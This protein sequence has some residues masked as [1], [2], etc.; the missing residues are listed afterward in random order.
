MCIYKLIH[1]HSCTNT[2]LCEIYKLKIYVNKYFSILSACIEK[3]TSTLPVNGLGCVSVCVCVCVCT[4]LCIDVNVYKHTPMFL[5]FFFFFCGTRAICSCLAATALNSSLCSLLDFNKEF[6]G[7][8]VC[9]EFY[10]FF[11]L[12]T[13]WN[14]FNFPDSNDN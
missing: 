1:P 5:I 9:N 8:K 2:H 4:C 14:V 12:H 11:F 10:F 3:S 13:L 7:Y 6:H